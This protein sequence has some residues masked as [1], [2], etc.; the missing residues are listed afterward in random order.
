LI[1][2]VAADAADARGDADDL[3]DMAQAAGSDGIGRGE[4]QDF[5]RL[6]KVLHR[7]TLSWLWLQE[8]SAPSGAPRQAQAPAFL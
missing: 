8:W 5:T 4:R 7:R 6:H 1:T 2:T 3:A